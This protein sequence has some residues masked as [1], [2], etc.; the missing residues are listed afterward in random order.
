M[1]PQWPFNY[2][3]VDREFNNQYA[4]ER[5]FGSLFLQFTVLGLLIGAFGIYGLIQLM[6]EYRKKEM[7][8][9]KVLGAASW[10]LARLIS[11]EYVI[12]M[13]VAFA[14]AIPLVYYLMNQWLADFAYHIDISWWMLT[15]PLLIVALV[16][17]LA[18]AWRIYQTTQTNPVDTLRYE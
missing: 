4:S 10:N 18:V 9:R 7:G 12:L 11:K 1:Y 13:L 6:T 3:L 15:S 2:L 14:V 5:S 16:S 8:I 17:T